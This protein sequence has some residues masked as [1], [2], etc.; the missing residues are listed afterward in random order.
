MS[1]TH[2]ER[3]A[4]VPPIEF[5]DLG[6]WLFAA[7]TRRGLTQ[8]QLADRCG[9]DQTG[10]S[11]IEKGLRWPTLAQLAQLARIL[12]VPIQW[13]INGQEVPGA[14]LPEL[15]VELHHLGIVD[16]LV[17]DA[18]VPGAFRPVEQVLAL[19]VSGDSPEPRIVEAIPAVLAWNW[20]YVPLLQSYGT[21]YDSRAA[22]RLGWLADVTLTIHRSH[23]FPGGCREQRKLELFVE[24]ATPRA[25]DDSLGHP[26]DDAKKRPPVSKR[27][28]VTYAAD[29]STFKERAEQLR[30]LL[31]RRSP[32]P[33]PPRPSG[34][35]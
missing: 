1:S 7:R 3:N 2:N 17:P 11:R 5:K 30:A 13:F 15:A 27:W 8:Q 21:V 25:E 9:L 6:R 18:V 10:V 35:E 24:W 23:G 31:Q 19:A 4:A 14:G 29:L 34:N 20:W 16:L 22:H 26:V 12:A 28:K 32:V 33:T